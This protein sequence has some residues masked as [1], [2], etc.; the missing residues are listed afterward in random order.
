MKS[1]R[2][3][4]PRKRRPRKAPAKPRGLK[5]RLNGERTLDE[6]RMMLID[7]TWRLDELGITH[8][9][10]VN[11]YLTPVSADGAPVTPVANGRMVTTLTIEEPYRSAADEHGL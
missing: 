7:A 4:P 3:P 9:R 10:G 2:L 6:L 5:I 11:I 8:V 1:P